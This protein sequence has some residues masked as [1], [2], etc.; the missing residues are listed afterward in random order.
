MEARQGLSLRTP[1][2]ERR[3]TLDDRHAAFFLDRLNS[4]SNDYPPDL[5]FNMDET[6]WRLFETPKKVLAE[7]GTETVKLRSATSDKTSFTAPGTISA[8]GRKLPL[9]VL[10]KGKTPRCPMHVYPR[11]RTERVLATAE[12]NDVELLFVPAGGTGRF[13]PLDRRVFG[14]L[15]SRARAEFGRRLGLAGGADIDYETS[16]DILVTCWNAIPTNNIRNAWNVV[17]EIE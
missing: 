6:C 9:R 14:E 17:S 10:A 7:K 11:H 16:V 13:Q 4:L 15:K 3:T 1:H 5:V 8:S 12:A 2:Q